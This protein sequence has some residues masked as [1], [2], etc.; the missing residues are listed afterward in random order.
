MNNSNNST[1][2]DIAHL[3]PNNMN[4]NLAAATTSLTTTTAAATASGY[5][6]NN[7]ISTMNKM[8]SISS[9]ALLSVVSGG[10]SNNNRSNSSN[11][12]V[13]INNHR[14]STRQSISSIHN[15]IELD[16]ER[17]FTQRVTVFN[18]AALSYSDSTDA[19]ISTMLKVIDHNEYFVFI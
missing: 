14:L 4:N 3:R 18:S 5:N 8:R 15:S 16:I 11:N 10:N 19:V 2:G 1:S 7:S 9:T 6:N 13:T 17:L 12:N